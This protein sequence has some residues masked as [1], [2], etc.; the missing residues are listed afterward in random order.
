MNSCQRRPVRP[1][2]E[3]AWRRVLLIVF[4]I[5]IVRSPT[6]SFGIWEI[7]HLSN[8]SPAHAPHWACVLELIWGVLAR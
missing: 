1:C 8:L 3:R 2:A 6:L 5:I 7:V 4:I